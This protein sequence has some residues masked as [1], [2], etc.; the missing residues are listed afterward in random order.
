[1]RTYFQDSEVLD[2][3]LKQ[4]KTIKYLMIYENKKVQYRMLE[5]VGFF[6]KE[7]KS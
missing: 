6:P 3:K 5:E 7:F 1:M 4:N 2:D